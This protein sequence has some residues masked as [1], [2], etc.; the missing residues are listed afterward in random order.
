MGGLL[1]LKGPLYLRPHGLAVREDERLVVLPKPAERR[2]AAADLRSR[3][4]MT[5]GISLVMISVY[6]YA[7]YFIVSF[8]SAY[9]DRLS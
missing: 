3:R 5:A 6:G 8:Y 9:F 7:I 1:A 2:Q 4:L